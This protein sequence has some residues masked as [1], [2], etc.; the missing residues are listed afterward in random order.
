MLLLPKMLQSIEILQLGNLE[1]EALVESSLVE[2]ETLKHPEEEKTEGTPLE[3]PFRDKNSRQKAREASD[4]FQE[5]LAN[6]PAPSGNLRQHLWEQV[7]LLGLSEKEESLLFAVIDEVDDNGYLKATVE[8]I[9]KGLDIAAS[10]EEIRRAIQTLQTFEPKGVGGS[11][12]LECL[13][14]QLD[15]ND[16]DHQILRHM[17][18]DF[19]EDISKNRIPKVAK[20]LGV[21]VERLK[22]IIGRLRVL[23]PKPGAMYSEKAVP[24]I[25]PD[26]V[27]ERRDGKLEIR[28]EDSFLPKLVIDETYFAMSK[29]KGTATEVRTYLK[30]KLE[31]A[32]WLVEAI[33][34]RRMTLSRVAHSV[35]SRQLEFLERGP[36]AV[37]PL[38]MKEVAEELGIHVSTVSRAVADK[39]VQ[40]PE[41]IY[42]LRMFFTATTEG[43]TGASRLS[44]REMVREMIEKEDSQS[45][46][47]DE[48]VV[49]KLKEKGVDVARRT[50]AKIRKELNIPSSWRR[51]SY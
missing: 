26:I 49:A 36:R 4:R 37:R 38:M 39:Y 17:L 13:L 15:E 25:R 32:R 11:G 20:A 1:L 22:E 46:L 28:I 44:V 2:N 30:E 45:P 7:A 50:A 5:W 24:T 34:Q 23:N 9:Q 3:E 27:V 8:E 21:E 12:P 40:V 10:E 35:F 29:D 33:E 6:A 19:L 41:G 16:P 48:E 18:V 42:P 47:S 14:L 31:S 43:E 51:R